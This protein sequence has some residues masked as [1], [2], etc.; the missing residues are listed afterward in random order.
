MELAKFDSLEPKIYLKY[1]CWQH[2]HFNTFKLG[3][4]FD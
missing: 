3:Q 2:S 1:A 4:K